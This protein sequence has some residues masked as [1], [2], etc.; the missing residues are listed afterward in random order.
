MDPQAQL[1]EQ[2]RTKAAPGSPLADRP[3]PPRRDRTILVVDDMPMIR[4][5]ITLYLRNEGFETLAAANGEE[6]L[7]LAHARPK[8]DLLLTDFEMPGMNGLELISQIHRTHPHTAVLLMSGALV[9][10]SYT[11]STLPKWIGYL[12]KPFGPA[13]LLRKVREA[14]ALDQQQPLAATGRRI[15]HEA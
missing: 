12:A 4:N 9:E 3:T 15:E 7:L 1:P 6:A 14:A 5:L 13:E 11:V 2:E 10:S 8:L